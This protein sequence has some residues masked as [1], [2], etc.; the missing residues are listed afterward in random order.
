MQKFTVTTIVAN[1]YSQECYEAKTVGAVY[2]YLFETEYI[3]TDHDDICTR[4]RNIDD[5]TEDMENEIELLKNTITI[6]EIREFHEYYHTGGYGRQEKTPVKEWTTILIEDFIDLNFTNVHNIMKMVEDIKLQCVHEPKK[7]VKKI[8][9]IE[10]IEN[11]ANQRKL[12][13]RLFRNKS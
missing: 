9:P 2:Q 13:N 5:D 12:H 6:D 1:N 4:F 8:K 3:L 7:E 11:I 10:N